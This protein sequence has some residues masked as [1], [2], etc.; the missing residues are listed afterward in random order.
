MA[1][2]MIG[3]DLNE[4]YCQISYYNEEQ[5]EPQ[6]LETL[7]YSVS[8]LYRR[9]VKRESQE[10]VRQL[11]VF[12]EESLQRFEKIG[13]LVFTVPELDVDIV[14]MLKGIGQRLGIAKDHITVQDYNESFCNYIR[15][16][17]NEC[18]F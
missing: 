1:K 14:R 9:A 4:R 10:I 16:Y 7:T 13:E 3:Y 12:V 6:T 18:F 2:H 5:K 11:K 17:F 8:D 15:Y